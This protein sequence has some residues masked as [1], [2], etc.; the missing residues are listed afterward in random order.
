MNS[1][2]D[3]YASKRKGCRRKCYIVCYILLSATV[4]SLSWVPLL[5][6]VAWLLGINMMLIAYLLVMSFFEVF[7][8]I[9]YEFLL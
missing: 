1:V 4:T 8:M 7:T 5:L 3:L 9:Y 6:Y 2:S